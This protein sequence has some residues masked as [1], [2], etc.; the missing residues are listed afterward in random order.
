M[1]ELRIAAPDLRTLHERLLSVAPAEGAAFLAVEPAGRDLVV[2]GAQVFGSE[3][4]DPD[5]AAPLALTEDAKVRAL[6]EIKRAGHAA[7]EVHT[8]PA[9]ESKVAFSRFDEAE[10]PAFARYV[11]RKIP[12]RPFG[13][14][15]FGK[16]SCAGLVFSPDGTRAPLKLRAV[17]EHKE[18]PS[19]LQTDGLPVVNDANPGS[20]FDR[21]IRALGPEG[22]RALER[23]RVAVVGLGGTG[24]VV[25]QQLAHLGV[26]RLV[27]VDDDRV[28]ATNLHRLAGGSFV[29][30]WLR[31]RKTAVA[32]RLVRRVTRGAKVETRESLRS[33]VTLEALKEV[34]VIIGCVDNDGARL[35]MSEL[36]AAYLIPYLDIGVG[37]EHDGPR[38]MGGRTSFFLPGGA[39][40]ACADDLDFGET[41]EDLETGPQRR[42]R[43]ARG[44]ARDRRIEAA[45]MPLNTT[46]AGL[47]MLELLAFATGV[48]RVRPHQR[49]DALA[50]RVIPINAPVDEQCPVCGPARGM[51]DRHRIERFA[52]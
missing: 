50:R 47:A 46:I 21:Q 10:L 4:V 17:G 20:R 11:Q 24:S 2:R 15:V 52:L 35:V 41:A 29:D 48:D 25:V 9:A 49:Y 6:A 31:R 19:W 42:L 22:Q 44:Y 26:R 8:H 34:E 1:M 51:G 5:E 23:I 45:L 13:A 38:A 7:V 3:D 39:C 33:R 16:R 32:R 43:E 14:L 12:N 37:I 18:G 40:L 28:E 27:L 36:A 30:A